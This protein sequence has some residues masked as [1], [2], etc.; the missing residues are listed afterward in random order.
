VSER[1]ESG[2]DPSASV[3]A[4][5]THLDW[6]VFLL[7]LITYG[8]FFQ[9]GG[10][11]QNSRFDQVRA[12]AEQGRLSINDYV[13][14][15]AGSDLD[16]RT[17]LTR[18]PLPTGVPLAKVG[19]LAN[20]QDVVQAEP[21]GL[22]YPNKP[23]GTVFLAVPA[24][25]TIYNVER[26]IGLDPD[27]WRIMTL[28]HYLTTVFSVGL[29][30]ALGGVLFLRFS[31]LLTPSAAE[32]THLAAT[33]TFG[34]GTLVLPYATVLFDHVQA[35]VL[36]LAAFYCLYRSG[37]VALTG[38]QQAL[39]LLLGGAAAGMSVLVNYV[40]AA[41]VLLL[42]GYAIWQCGLRPRVLCFLLGGL[43]FALILGAYHAACFGS[44]FAT[45]NVLTV[46]GFRLR[47]MALGTFGLPDPVVAL[48]LLFG[49]RR[50]LLL[51]SPVLLLA[52]VGAFLAFRRK[53]SRAPVVL[54]L[55]VFLLYWMVNSSFEH[56]HAGFAIGPRYM[57]PALPFLCLWLAR[58]FEALHRV[59]LVAAA[60][61]LL[62]LFFA[63]AV[64]A[65]APPVF[66]NPFSQY[67]WPLARD[68]SF[69]IG[70]IEIEGPISVNPIGTWEGWYY[71][72]FPPGSLQARW[73]SFNLGEMVW[74]RSWFSLLPL[75]LFLAAGIPLA[76]RRSLRL[77]K[78]SAPVV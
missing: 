29:I 36:L 31:R 19:H 72:V 18:L 77:R 47:G 58:S 76:A 5:S 35:G 54:C 62:I 13:L 39:W 68:G 70:Q 52:F 55:L 10:W 45:A 51:T 63:T 61:S 6:V 21:S 57:V 34:L 2:E 3:A 4:G 38:R 11:N 66:S 65:Q 56:W 28:N 14:Y 12:I 74:P 17:T 41:V 24:Y 75:V 59:T 37:S 50:G 7:L 9:G 67:L 43:P 33:L 44:P 32:W 64:D 23:P 53:E 78:R 42:T 1:S 8:Y 73:S 60:L 69:T 71:R 22:S 25:L 15:R 48:K 40:C 20:T 30:G 16:G 27:N 46:E 26:L 49:T